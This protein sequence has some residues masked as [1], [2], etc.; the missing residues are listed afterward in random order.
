MSRF[1]WQQLGI[2]RTDDAGAI[3]RAYAERLKSLDL[4]RDMTAYADLREARDFAL[5][6]A[7]RSQA[8]PERDGDY[9]APGG[10]ADDASRL[11]D[12]V[13]YDDDD[14]EFAWSIDEALLEDR[15]F[16]RD[17]R[18]DPYE[19]AEASLAE[20][21]AA[22][23]ELAALHDRA[24]IAWEDLSALLFPG[25][26]PSDDGFDSAEWGTA[27]D[28]LGALITTIDV[29]PLDDH[30]RV[31]IALAD[32]LARGWPRSAPLVGIASERFEWLAQEGALDEHPALQFLNA[33]LRGMR[34]HEAVQSPS[35][36]LHRAWNE[37][38]N[39]RL[40]RCVAQFG[41]R[42]RKVIDLIATVRN[43]FP[44]LEHYFDGPR[45]LAWEDS[46]GAL[47]AT[48]IRVA[49]VLYFVSIVL[50]GLA[51]GASDAPP[52]VDPPLIEAARSTVVA[53]AWTE[54][55]GEA[56]DP[57]AARR[58][59][60]WF[61]DIFLARVAAAPVTEAD[62]DAPNEAALGFTRN[63]MG[64]ALETAPFDDLVALQQVRLDWLR[65]ARAHGGDEACRAV[66]DGEI[67]SLR[68]ALPP[69]QRAAERK[70]AARLLHTGKLDQPAGRPATSHDIPGWLVA[71]VLETSDLSR[72]Q[73]AAAL[74]NPEDS[75]RCE[76]VTAML[77]AMVRQ[78]GK[79][80]AETLRFF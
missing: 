42:R 7:R 72:E 43:H 64:A 27:Q 50:K 13:D 79:V 14:E 19:S 8:E 21:A 10:P 30:R 75:R 56:I 28:A 44:E 16:G 2:A 11:D 58:E 74:G 71:A 1:P 61:T 80:P 26:Q 47:M 67:R 48:V 23:P 34:F 76:V 9:A 38:T 12:G 59:A 20:P 49:L 69:D 41:I 5:A 51:G 52:V 3:R 65:A 54:V 45:T 18:L 29:M 33:R 25:N 66:L 70:L 22:D 36:P 73:V 62:P 46:D 24:R 77:A 53:S 60:P 63:I 57:D 78:P 39:P 17:A 68:L 55:F 31:E 35:H 6:E 4:D 37:L 32:L 40:P 15:D